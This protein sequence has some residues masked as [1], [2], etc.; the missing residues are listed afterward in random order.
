MDEGVEGRPLISVVQGCLSR[1]CDGER[2][3]LAA[4]R[5]ECL[6]FFSKKETLAAWTSA[7]DG[8]GLALVWIPGHS[9]IKMSRPPTLTL[10]LVFMVSSVG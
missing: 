2:R 4:H 7:L 3:V 9:R 6:S 8:L 1:Q 10:V 5:R